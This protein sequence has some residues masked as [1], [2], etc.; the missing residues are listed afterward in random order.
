MNQDQIRLF[1]A[2]LQ[3]TLNLLQIHHLPLVVRFLQDPLL[4]CHTQRRIFP[5]LNQNIRNPTS[6]NNRCPKEMTV[7]T[8]IPNFT[9]IHYKATVFTMAINLLL[10]HLQ[11]HRALLNSIQLI[12]FPT[13]QL[14]PP[15]N[16]TAIPYI[17]KILSD[18]IIL[19]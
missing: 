8:L 13:L 14:R 4:K 10:P 15:F 12:Q 2:H 9:L 3:S 11:I 1:P 16:P 19:P 18:R 7:L 5:T 6:R 17:F